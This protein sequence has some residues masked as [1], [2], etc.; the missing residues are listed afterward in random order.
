[1]PAGADGTGAAADVRRLA[2]YCL[3][4]VATLAAISALGTGRPW[5]DLPLALAA[6]LFGSLACRE[7]GR[8]SRVVRATGLDVILCLCLPS[9][10]IAGQWLAPD[11]VQP[12]QAGFETLHILGWAIV[13]FV[14]G[15]VAA[16]DRAMLGRIGIRLVLPAAGASLAALA[17][18][19]LAVAVLHQNAREA[20]LLQVVP[21]MAGG[22]AAGA[23]PL[24]VGYA[25]QMEQSAGAV[26]AQILPSVLAGNLTGIFVAGLLGH[27]RPQP[28]PGATLHRMPVQAAASG[29]DIALALAA[30]VALY[31]SGA[32][33][34]ALWALPPTLTVVLL[35]SAAALLGLL[36]P[37]L[38]RGAVAV[39]AFAARNLL[40]PLLWLV[41]MLILPWDL[42]V[43]G[44]TLPR[45]GVAVTVVL[46]LAAAGFLLSRPAGIDRVEGA[47]IAIAR[48]S[49]GGTG[50]LAMLTAANRLSALPFAL[51]VL[52]LGGALTI[53]LALQLAS[54]LH[55]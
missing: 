34:D 29:R 2:A 4:L 44:L 1:M 12:F 50:T 37:S 10:L 28:G 30:L 46:T 35:A 32:A 18:G 22:L 15:G 23:L 48:A 11:V 39:S 52:R 24:S 47:I 17:A 6:M 14:L 13:V 25:A 45:L 31:G 3:A 40:F 27:L 36:P 54:L 55:P 20:F 38:R 21:I 26:L 5:I 9:M 51:L 19:G 41:G 49:M 42:I 8:N 33:L 43:A 7:L 16:V 53:A